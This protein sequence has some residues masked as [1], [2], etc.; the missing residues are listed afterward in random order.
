MSPFCTRMSH[1]VFYLAE[2]KEFLCLWISP[3][4]FTFFAGV[5]RALHVASETLLIPHFIYFQFMYECVGS[6]AKRIL[7]C[8]DGPIK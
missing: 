3:I 5:Y 2:A 1:G 8:K 7:G 4:K 6:Q